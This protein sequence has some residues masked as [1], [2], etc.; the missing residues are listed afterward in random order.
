[1]PNP[2]HVLLSIFGTPRRYA[3]VLRKLAILALG[4]VYLLTFLLRN[5]PFIDTTFATLES[6]GKLGALG[7]AI[8]PYWEKVNVSGFFIAVMV[9]LLSHIFKFHDRLSDIFRLRARFDRNYILL[10]MA[11]MV[12]ARLT[13]EKVRSLELNRQTIMHRVFYKYAS[14]D[15]SERIAET[16]DI[17]HALAHWCWI[18]FF[19]EGACFLL[20][21]ALASVFFSSYGLTS[22]LLFAMTFALLGL[23]YCYVRA[24]KYAAPQ[25]DSIARNSEAASA[26]RAEFD[27]L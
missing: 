5:V 2:L 21:T 25:V 16:H 15:A 7:S 14:I 3:D 24:E 4:E 27:A 19:L 6:Y 9:A 22:G 1:M 23:Q 8:G 17:E 26:V 10:P 20:V 12:G 13:L 11:T 18:W